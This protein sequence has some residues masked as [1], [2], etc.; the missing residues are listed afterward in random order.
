MTEWNSPLPLEKNTVS[1]YSSFFPSPN[2]LL[3]TEH[4]PSWWNDE[5]GLLTFSVLRKAQYSLDTSSIQVYQ[6]KF[7]KDEKQEIIP[8][9]IEL[10]VHDLF[11]WTELSGT[12]SLR[13]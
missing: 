13:M 6:Y 11:H 12:V 1:Y 8:T 7:H 5:L 4:Q 10:C 9:I 2:K 3:K